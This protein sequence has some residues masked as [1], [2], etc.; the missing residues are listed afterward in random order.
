LR[1]CLRDIDDDQVSCTGVLPPDVTGALERERQLLRERLRQPD[2]YFIVTAVAAELHFVRDHDGEVRDATV[3][4][5]RR[6][7]MQRAFGV[8]AL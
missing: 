2:M 8:D 1:L 4:A 3:V 7:R 5:R 6:A